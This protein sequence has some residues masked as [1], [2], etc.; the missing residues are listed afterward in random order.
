MNC[1]YCYSDHYCCQEYCV[2]VITL[3]GAVALETLYNRLCNIEIHHYEVNPCGN[4]SKWGRKWCH[5]TTA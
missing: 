2:P 1:W 3:T 4:S 5:V